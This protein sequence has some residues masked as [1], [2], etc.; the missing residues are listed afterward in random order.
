MDDAPDMAAGGVLDM[1]KT[2]TLTEALA[3]SDSARSA[4]AVM[5]DIATLVVVDALPVDYDN[6]LIYRYRLVRHGQQIG[7]EVIGWPLDGVEALSHNGCWYPLKA[8][9]DQDCIF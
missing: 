2:M 6:H 1:T 3:A 5:E 7:Q 9:S 4:F 8:R